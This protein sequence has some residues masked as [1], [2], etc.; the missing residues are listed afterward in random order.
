MTGSGMAI[1]H[2]DNEKTRFQLCSG[3]TCCLYSGTGPD[4]ALLCPEGRLG[5]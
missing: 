1:W 4:E 3:P 2:S 5:S